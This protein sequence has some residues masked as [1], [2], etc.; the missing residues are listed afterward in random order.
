MESQVIMVYGN[1]EVPKTAGANFIVVKLPEDKKL[2]RWNKGFCPAVKRLLRPWWEPSMLRG[3]NGY[4]AE[5]YW[6]VDGFASKED[7]KLAWETK[8]TRRYI[9]DGN[10]LKEVTE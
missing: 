8:K 4:P 3:R 7:E 2:R 10:E 6:N 1:F 9:W 5:A